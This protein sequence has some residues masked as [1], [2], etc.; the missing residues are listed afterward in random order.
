MKHEHDIAYPLYDGRWEHDAC[1]TGFLA[2][3]SGEAS[4][5]V[6][7]T[8]LE[9]L[10]RL[11]HR[12]AQDAD[13]ETSDGAGILTQI[14][15]ALL[16]EELE[17]RHISLADP[18]DLA[19]GMIFL[20][21]AGG[22]NSARSRDLIEQTISNLGLTF[23]GWRTPPIDYRVLGTRAR[24]TAP[25]I[26]QVLISR[27]AHLT[28]SL[29]GQAL[30]RARRLMERALREEQIDD[31]YIVSLSHTT[32]IYKGLL[33]PKELSRFY[34]D[35]SDPR[36]TSALVVLHQRYSTNTLP[37]WPLA[38]PMRLLAHNGEINTIQGNRNWME[39][40]EGSLSAP[41]W[42]DDIRDVLPVL[43]PDA[44]DS[45]QLDNALELLA[46]SGR[47]LLESVQMLVPPAWEH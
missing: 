14:P 1:G 21:P 20:P 10:A 22:A 8:A 7:V 46:C 25:E 12:G 38:Q 36:Y 9:A 35:L 37:A 6:V 31:C 4:H 34:T 19:V 27:P 41:S 33:A 11:T 28:F 39:A 45:A 43:Q 40:R 24:Q 32:V 13:A 18:A 44:S 2:S 47:D 26:M 3:V 5:T 23:L 17:Q 15:R 29:Y 30:Y 16:L 42:G